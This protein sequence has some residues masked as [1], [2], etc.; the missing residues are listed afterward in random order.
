MTTL[1]G[2]DGLSVRYHLIH[3]NNFSGNGLPLFEHQNWDSAPH[4]Y[5]TKYSLKPAISVQGSLCPTFSPVSK[6][7]NERQ[8][9]IGLRFK[10]DE[11]GILKKSAPV[12]GRV[13]IL[14]HL[15]C[16]VAYVI[17]KHCK[18]KP[19]ATLDF[20]QFELLYELEMGHALVSSHY[21]FASLKSLLQ[22]MP[23]IV[24]LRSISPVMADWRIYP[25]V[26]VSTPSKPLSKPLSI[27]ALRI[28]NIFILLIFNILL[29]SSLLANDREMVRAA[30]VEQTSAD[31]IF[32]AFCIKFFI[33]HGH[34]EFPKST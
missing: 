5:G 24:A 12:G 26:K 20:E 22:S 23:D 7:E 25:H 16:E 31:M 29:T 34:L 8:Q 17:E 4:V 18:G 9:Q 6:G 15:R 33:R 32:G 1:E 10:T 2:S 21:G 19:K 28:D 14:R 11:C 30:K 13:R 27:F 3:D